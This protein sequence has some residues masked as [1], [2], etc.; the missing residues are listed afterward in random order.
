MRIPK[1]TATL[2]S[3]ALVA[4]FFFC[5]GALVK[6]IPLIELDNKLNVGDFAAGLIALGSLGAAIYFLPLVINRSLSKR[7]ARDGFIV[8]DLDE[9]YD[10][11]ISLKASYRELSSK[12]TRLTAQ[13]RAEILFSITE[14]SNL[15]KE[16]SKNLKAD[17]TDIQFDE[18]V[19][20]IFNEKTYPLL[21]EDLQAGKII[22]KQ[23]FLD[24]SRSLNIITAE[25]KRCR[26]RTFK[27]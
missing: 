1:F 3:Y 25:I 6:R 11:L 24:A 17:H 21:T 9:I 27:D 5:L 23:H 19:K 22:K 26:Y 4:T 10:Q 2:T 16:L 15:I 14:V 7:D 13:K 20:N 8:R 12:G 18:K